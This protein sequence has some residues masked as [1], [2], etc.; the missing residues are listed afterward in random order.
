MFLPISGAGHFKQQ[1]PTVAVTALE[2]S[3]VDD[4]Q[5]LYIGKAAAGSNDAGRLRRRIRQLRQFG[6]GEPVVHWGGRYIWQHTDHASL[7]VA[8]RVTEGEDPRNVESKLIDSSTSVTAARHSPISDGSVGA[9]SR[10]LHLHRCT[11]S[12]A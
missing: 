3:W 9:G 11:R 2:R 6:V 12:L 1:D 10:R 4:A 8:W 5:V 7:L